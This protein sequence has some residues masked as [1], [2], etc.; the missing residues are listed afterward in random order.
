MTKI[1][2]RDVNPGVWQWLEDY[3]YMGTAKYLIG[4][5]WDRS[6]RVGSGIFTGGMPQGDQKVFSGNLEWEV[7]GAGSLHVKIEDEGG[8]CRIGFFR[9]STALFEVPI[10]PPPPFLAD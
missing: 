6:C 2:W 1:I 9:R 10:Y 7:L 5:P 3:V 8:P 4:C